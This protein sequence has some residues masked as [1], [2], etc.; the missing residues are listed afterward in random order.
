MSGK[1]AKALRKI[2]NLASQGEPVSSYEER[3]TSKPIE[4]MSGHLLGHTTQVVLRDKCARKKYKQL[5]ALYRKR[6]RAGL[7]GGE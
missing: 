3:G 1:S 7:V 5:K 4:E 2:A 6:Q